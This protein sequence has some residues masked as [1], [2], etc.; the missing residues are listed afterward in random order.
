MS[1]GIQSVKDML[2]K[3][4]AELDQLQSHIDEDRLKFK[5]DAEVQASLDEAQ[6][7]VDAKRERIKLMKL[8]ADTIEP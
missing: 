8:I 6:F 3:V 1:D 4:T 5:D 2:A 7:R